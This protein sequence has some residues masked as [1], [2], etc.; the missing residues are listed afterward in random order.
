MGIGHEGMLTAAR[1]MAE[2]AFEV[3]TDE[4]LLE[5]AKADFEQKTGGR[6]Y[7]SA[8]PPDLEPAFHQFAK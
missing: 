6:P 2:A 3:M 8:L 1:V 7:V 5:R 4:E